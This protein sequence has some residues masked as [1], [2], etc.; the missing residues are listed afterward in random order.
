MFSLFES[1][2]LRLREYAYRLIGRGEVHQSIIVSG[3]PRSG[4]TWLAQI[5]ASLPGYKHFNEPLRLAPPLV[6]KLGLEERNYVAPSASRAELREYLSYALRG[7]VDG[8]YQVHGTSKL[9]RTYE[10]LQRPQVVAKFIR[11][12]RMVH[13]LD[14]TFDVRGLFVLLRHPCAVVS[15]HLQRWGA[16]AV[17]DDFSTGFGGDIPDDLINQ[18]REVLESIDTGEEVLA[19]VWAIDTYC[20][21][22]HHGSS[23]GPVITYE[24]LRAYPEEIVTDLFAHVGAKVPESAWDHV[25]LP[26]R[27]AVPDLHVDDVERQL[28]KW[29]RKLSEDQTDRILRIARGFGLDMYGRDMYPALDRIDSP[30]LKQE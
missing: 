14:A 29:T 7:K 22:R 2:E 9:R 11:A 15:S 27:S 19:A 3:S 10:M 17:P 21:L 23:P 6:R 12:N 13:W 16:P 28:S 8:P 4:T 26:S 30:L 18:Y 20:V 24:Q 25:D 5:L 1:P